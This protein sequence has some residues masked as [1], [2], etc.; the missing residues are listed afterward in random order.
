MRITPE[1]IDGMSRIGFIGQHEIYIETDDEIQ[2]PHFHIRDKDDWD[3]FHTC[4]KIETAEYFKHGSKDGEL[5]NKECK[6]LDKFM[7][8][9]YK[10]R[11][12]T[13]WQHICDSWDDNNSDVI[14]PDHTV[15]PDYTQLNR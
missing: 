9:P 14:I 15:Q 10:N 5:N 7:R 4:V 1:G 3:K 2:I 11:G 8:Q 6:A 13:N 12:I